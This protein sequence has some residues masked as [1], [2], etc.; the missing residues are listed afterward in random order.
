MARI[1][2]TKY[3]S[4]ADYKVYLTDVL[5]EERYAEILEGCRLTPSLGEADIKVYITQYISDADIIITRR[6]FPRF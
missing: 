6:K 5:S 1:Y 4:E 2:I 3:Q